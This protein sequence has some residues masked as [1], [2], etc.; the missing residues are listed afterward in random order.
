MKTIRIFI[1]AALAVVALGLVSC[2]KSKKKD[3]TPVVPEVA[4]KIAG[5]YDGQLIYSVGGVG[6][7]LDMTVL[8]RRESESAVA[9]VIPSVGMG[10]PELSASGVAVSTSDYVLYTLADTDF[11]ETVNNVNYSGTVGG[12]VNNGLL[13]LHGTL[14]PGAMPMDIVFSFTSN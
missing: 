8:L 6:D 10:M 5:T 13:T 11:R 2:N 9:V 3:E 7:T 4:G 12:T 14:R 1:F